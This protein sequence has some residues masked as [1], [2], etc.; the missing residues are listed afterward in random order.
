[1]P[2]ALSLAVVLTCLLPPLVGQRPGA[3][4]SPEVLTKLLQQYDKNKN[5]KIE[6]SEYP[7]TEAAFANLD[8]DRNGL[9][10]AT[11]FESVPGRGQRKGAAPRGQAAEGTAKL[12]KVGDTAPDFDLPMLG[13]KDKTVK[14]SSFRGKQAVALIFGSYT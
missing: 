8:R 7:R 4:T 9:I 13:M 14:L 10:D 1:M 12:P 6:R 5:G 11:D 3:Q 2:N